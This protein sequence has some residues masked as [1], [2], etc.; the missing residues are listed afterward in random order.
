[1]RFLKAKCMKRCIKK[2]DYR[3]TKSME[4]KREDKKV[5]TF[6]PRYKMRAE[7]LSLFMEATALI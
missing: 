7:V 4:K 6:H 5:K 3:K 2:Q 1:M